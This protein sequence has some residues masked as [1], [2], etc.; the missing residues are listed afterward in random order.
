MAKKKKSGPKLVKSPKS[1]VWK[2]VKSNGSTKRMYYMISS[3]GRVKS[4]DK[5]SKDEHLIKGTYTKGGYH[6]FNIKLEDGKRQTFYVHRLVAELYGGRKKKN[7][8]VVCHK[9]GNKQNNKKVVI[10]L[11]LLKQK[12]ERSKRPLRKAT[13]QKLL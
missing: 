3:N 6:Q 12:L 2:K 5:K 4:V 13:K 10:T 11:S 9:D 8:V 1:E 7:Q